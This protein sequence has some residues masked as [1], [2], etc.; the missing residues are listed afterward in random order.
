LKLEIDLK[1]FESLPHDQ[2][3]QIFRD[4][5][6]SVKAISEEYLVKVF[7]YASG[8]DGEI[9]WVCEEDKS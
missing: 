5:Q 1:A 7:F 8:S 2:Q 3:I 9:S 6:A 4:I